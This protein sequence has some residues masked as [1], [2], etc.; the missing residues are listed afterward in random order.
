[1]QSRRLVRQLTALGLVAAFCVCSAPQ[2]K[3]GSSDP[4]AR[5]DGVQSGAISLHQIKD[6]TML[7]YIPK[8]GGAVRRLKLSTP[9]GIFRGSFE[10]A[11]LIGEIPNKV[12]LLSDTYASR[13]NGGS[14][15]CG[16]GQETFLRVV[17]LGAP[18]KETATIRVESCWRTYELLGDGI[19][20]IASKR[21]V[22]IF[23]F[24]PDDPDPKGPRE[25]TVSDD[26][27]VKRIH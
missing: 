20:W 9:D 12:V 23:L 10:S 24:T 3:A 8:S 16:A 18:L 5:L 15:E 26:G 21:L 13:P 22:R 25:Y 14:H 2:A 19:N 6:V 7:T 11:N 27:A 1:M 17:A 4:P